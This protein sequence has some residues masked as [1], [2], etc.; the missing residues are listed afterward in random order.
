MHAKCRCYKPVSNRQCHTPA[1]LS[2][3]HVCSHIHLQIISANA[4]TDACTSAFA[5]ATMQLP[6]HSPRQ[7]HCL[8]RPPRANAKMPQICSKRQCYTPATLATLPPIHIC[9]LSALLT[10][11]TDF[12]I[13]DPP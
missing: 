3:T 12:T 13:V 9:S 7:H 10:D 8:S 6:T 2:L 4:A 1:T 11:S 5:S